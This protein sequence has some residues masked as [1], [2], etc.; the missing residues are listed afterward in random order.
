MHIEINS[1]IKI[2]KAYQS[3]ISQ[4]CDLLNELF[5]IEADFVAAPD[6]QA[7]G[8]QLLLEDK[9]RSLVLVAA[10][11]NE[12]VGMCSVQTLLSTSE[13]S[14]VG[15][16]E[17]VVVRNDYRGKGVATSLLANIFSWCEEKGITRVQLLA[18][19]GNQEALD[20]YVSREWI[21]TNL[22]C[23]RKFTHL[24][25]TGQPHQQ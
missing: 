6:K 19:R 10:V 18:D 1:N 21:H 20:F 13:G 15:L 24:K 25:E 4:M 2:R 16:V 23:M 17:D 12:V 22:I 7:R 3:D 5:S 11:G 8:L 9:D 14:L